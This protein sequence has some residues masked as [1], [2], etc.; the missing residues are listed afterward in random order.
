MADLLRRLGAFVRPSD[1]SQS[2]RKNSGENTIRN[3]YVRIRND[4]QNGTMISARNS[5]R[6][7]SGA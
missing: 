7:C 3:E 5:P 4:V 6:R 2:D 1:C